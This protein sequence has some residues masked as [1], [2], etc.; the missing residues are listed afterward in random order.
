MAMELATTP[1][2]DVDGDGLQDIFDGCTDSFLDWTSNL[3]TDHDG[4]GCRDVDGDDDD[5]N[6]GVTTHRTLAR[7]G[8]LDGYLTTHP[9]ITI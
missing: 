8:L 5:D 2:S 3:T 7:L 1:I 4:D 9:Q 6:D